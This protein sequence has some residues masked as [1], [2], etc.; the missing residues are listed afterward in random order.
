MQTF[1]QIKGYLNYRI[2]PAFKTASFYTA[3][4]CL[5]FFNDDCA[6]REDSFCLI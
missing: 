4:K 5:F 1:K 2:I 3:S 6:I